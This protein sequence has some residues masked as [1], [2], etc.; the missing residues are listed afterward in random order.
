MQKRRFRDQLYPSLEPYETGML[1][2]DSLHSM[3]WEQSGNPTGIP[4]F[5]YT[6]AQEL[7]HFLVI[8]VFLIPLPI[9]L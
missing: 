1:K 5:F 3:Y 4:I 6:V 7:D 9:E 2:L 8:G